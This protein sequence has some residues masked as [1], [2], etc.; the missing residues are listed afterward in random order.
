[1]Y[2][3]LQIFRTKHNMYTEEKQK[4]NIDQLLKMLLEKK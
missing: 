4:D 1:M 3:P 2:E